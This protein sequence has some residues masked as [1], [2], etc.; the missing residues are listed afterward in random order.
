[1]EFINLVSL[2]PIVVKIL[3]VCVGNTCRS[4]MAEAIARSHGHVATSAGTHPGEEVSESVLASP[5]AILFDQ[6]ENRL[7]MQ[8]AILRQLTQS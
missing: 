3:F 8:K 1:M 6:A 2:I 4:Q 7:H 5:Q